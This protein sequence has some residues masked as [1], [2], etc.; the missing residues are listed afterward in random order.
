MQITLNRRVLL[1]FIFLFVVYAIYIIIITAADRPINFNSAPKIDFYRDWNDY[2]FMEYEASRSGPGE[3]GVAVHLDDQKEIEMNEKLL[4]KTGFSAVVSDKISLNRSLPKLVHQD[5]LDVK[6]L[7][8]LPKTSV[9]IIFYNEVLSVLL[10]TV[11]SVYNR[12][13]KELLHEIILVNDHSSNVDDYKELSGY[14][15]ANFQGTKAKVKELTKRSGLIRARME[16]AREATGEVLVFFD[17]HVEVQNNW[18]PP[19]LEPI[20]KNRKIA[21]LPIVDYFDCR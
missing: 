6:Y 12:T 17:S 20:V 16:G 11:H 19:L 3:H 7:A 18:L 21:T 15:A 4:A 8:E 5:C 9:I 2:K 14:L 13:P 10:R 1:P